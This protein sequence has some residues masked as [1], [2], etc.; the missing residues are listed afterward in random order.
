M[1]ASELITVNKHL[2]PKIWDQ[3]ELKPEIAD[4]LK[5]IAEAF[6]DFVGVELDVKDLTVTGSN[7]NYTWTAYSDLDLHIIVPGIPTEQERE[8]YTAKKN[9]WS[10]Q[11]D[12]KIRNMPVEVYIQGEDEQ[13]HSTGVYSIAKQDWLTVPKKTKPKI[14][15]RAV[16]AKYQ[17]IAWGIGEALDSNNLEKLQRV[18]DKV[19]QMR[20]SG[21]SRAGEWSVENLVFKQLRNVGLIDKMSD[22]IRRLQDQELSLEQANSLD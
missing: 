19:T 18:K 1:R 2:N 14:D 11:H 5:K 9:L 22:R 4:K 15:D 8:L 3:G 7:A 20:K 17:E 21:L 10:E 13:H 16:S 6:L 12:I